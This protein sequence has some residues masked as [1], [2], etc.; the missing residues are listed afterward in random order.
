MTENLLLQL[1]QHVG[2]VAP[3]QPA[4]LGQ[5]HALTRQDLVVVGDGSASRLWASSAGRGRRPGCAPIP[6]GHGN[7]ARRVSVRPSC[8]LVGHYSVPVRYSLSRLDDVRARQSHKP[9]RQWSP[10][11]PRS[12]P[13]CSPL[14]TC[15]SRA[16]PRRRGG[17]SPAWGWDAR[18]PA[19]RTPVPPSGSGSFRWRA[20]HLRRTHRRRSASTWDRGSHRTP[21]RAVRARSHGI[22]TARTVYRL[23]PRH[24]AM[25]ERGDDGGC[26]RSEADHGIVAPTS[27][28]SP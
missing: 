28:P 12:E 21:H 9:C 5:I 7:I 13:P 4:Q 27:S 6:R 10:A 2:R 3:A 1:C 22:V 16:S 24:L 8:R 20:C 25:T 11:S 18:R 15:T 17:R 26:R 23:R 14:W 19:S